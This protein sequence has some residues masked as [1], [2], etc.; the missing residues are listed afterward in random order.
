MNPI[1]INQHIPMLIKKTFK[2]SCVYGSLQSQP[3]VCVGG[4]AKAYI[5]KAI[6]HVNNKLIIIEKAFPEA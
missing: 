6:I 2:N 3:G 4:G 1:Y 5:G